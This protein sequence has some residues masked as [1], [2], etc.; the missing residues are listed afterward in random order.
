MTFSA[1]EFLQIDLPAMLVAMLSAISC[2]ILGSFLVL[3]RQALIGDALSHVVLP[4]IVVGFMVTNSVATWPMMLGALGA[5]LVA[6]AL[7]EA[8]KRLGSLEPGAA[9]GVVFTVMFAAGVVL[10][11][12]GVGTR[13]HLDAQHALYGALE[14]TL[15]T[16]PF[17]WSDLADPAI[18]LTLPRQI[19]ALFVVMLLVIALTVLFFKELKITTFDPGLAAS[20]GLP[21]TVINLGLVLMVAVAAVAS[22][23]AVGSILVIAMFIC[24]AATARLLTD[25]LSTQLVLSGLIGAASGLLG[26]VCA[27]WLPL[28]LG[29]ENSLTAAGMIAVLAG[30]LQ[31]LAMLFAPRYGVVIRR[32]RRRSSAG[33]ANAS[34]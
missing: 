33:G 15:W 30:F 10:L 32:L 13:V 20:L 5:A 8:I 26:Y 31:L 34:A 3:R 19:P 27:A 18:W 17:G 28:M 2:G 24:P 22:F 16:E 25:R 11:E 9:M 21:V 14:T 29:A 7:I 23:E 4:G 6:V 12:R 1:L